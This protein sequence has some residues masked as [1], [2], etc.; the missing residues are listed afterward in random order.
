MVFKWFNMGKSNNWNLIDFFHHSANL[1]DIAKMNFR[2][3]F[4]TSEEKYQSIIVSINAF[5]PV[6]V[7][8]IAIGDFD[9]FSVENP[10]FF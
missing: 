3:Y 6:W 2:K 7:S 4:N 10:H 5:V 9:N 8:Q 1:R